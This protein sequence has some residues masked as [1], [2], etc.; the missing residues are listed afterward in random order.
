M[1]TY[2]PE[3]THGTSKP[4]WFAL[5]LINKPL[6]T[7]LFKTNSLISNSLDSVVS[8]GKPGQTSFPGF[9]SVKTSKNPLTHS[10]V[11]V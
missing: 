4:F 7:E 2:T 8:F 6:T 11:L 9:L 3:T 5:S 10:R 1:L